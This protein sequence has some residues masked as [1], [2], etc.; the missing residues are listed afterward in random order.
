[1]LETP[2]IISVHEQSAA[3]IRI[4]VPQSDI[5]PS[6]RQRSKSSGRRWPHRASS[7]PAR[8]SR[9]TCQWTTLCSTLVGFPVEGRLA[10]TGRVRCGSLPA[11]T[12]ARATYRGGYEG[13]S[14][15]WGELRQWT[16][17]NGHTRGVDLWEVYASGP[18]TSSN[19]AEWRTE[20]NQP[21]QS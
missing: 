11:A 2:S 8:C 9:I 15:A 13:L 16:E 21:L 12:L 18:E 3:I 20:L 4:T 19:A 6:C 7:R 17:A 10:E 14:A 5:R 1:M